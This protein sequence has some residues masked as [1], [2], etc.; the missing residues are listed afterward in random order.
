MLFWVHSQ[1]IVHV[2]VGFCKLTKMVIFEA[3][4]VWEPLWVPFASSHGY[5][6]KIMGVFCHIFHS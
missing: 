1:L 6:S 5:L 4:E 2:L 3:V